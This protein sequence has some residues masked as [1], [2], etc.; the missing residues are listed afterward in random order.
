MRTINELM[1]IQGRCA[2]ITGATGHLGET[3]CHTLSELGCNVVIVDISADRCQDL[4][5]EITAR[6]GTEALA[7]K[8]D[9]AVEDDVVKIPEIVKEHFGRM[10]IL[11][12]NAAYVGTSGLQGW[13]TAFDKQLTST[14]RQA[15]EVN[16]SAVFTLCRESISLLKKSGNGSIINIASIYGLLGPD[17]K[18]YDGTEMGNPA[19]YAASKGGLIQ[20]TRWLSTTCAPEIR[21]NS[22]SP[23]GIFRNQDQSFLERYVAKTPLQRMADEEDFKGIIAYLSSDMSKYVT[24]QNFTVDGGF[25][26]W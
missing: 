7:L 6:Y 21:T 20:F 17:W 22:I 8:C 13:A 10:D 19:A 14:W 4:A 18:L 15:L 1:S 16:L 23:G 24:G 11:I 3:F 2:V 25:S 12:N 26:A 5:G 9:L